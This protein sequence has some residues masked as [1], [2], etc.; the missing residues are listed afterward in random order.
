MRIITKFR[1]RNQHSGTDFKS[2]RQ[3]STFANEFDNRTPRKNTKRRPHFIASSRAVAVLMIVMSHLLLASMPP[4]ACA[5]VPS[6]KYQPLSTLRKKHS[7]I[8]TAIDGTSR[9]TPL[10]RLPTQTPDTTS[11]SSQHDYSQPVTTTSGF[12][13]HHTINSRYTNLKLPPSQ[14]QALFETYHQYKVIRE[15]LLEQ[16]MISQPLSVQASK[17]NISPSILQSI[18]SAG[19]QARQTLLLANVPLVRHTVKKITNAQKLTSSMLSVEDLVQEGT[20]GLT[21]AIDKFDYKL[22]TKFSTYAVYWIRASVIR[23]I[24][25][26]EELIRVP[27]YLEKA[28]RVIDGFMADRRHLEV[29]LLEKGLDDL[30]L[31]HVA[32]VTG[33]S[34]S[35]I[36]EAFRVKQRRRLLYSKKEA[37]RE[38]EDYMLEASSISTLMDSED[39]ET[40][41]DSLEHK[42]HVKDVLGQFLSMKEMEALSWR[43]GLLEEEK[44]HQEQQRQLQ[45]QQDHDLNNTTVNS[46][47]ENDK[48]SVHQVRD[49]QA[50]A[51][52]DL[53]GPDGILRM[54][55]GESV[56]E[57]IQRHD[58][59]KSKGTK[60][61]IYI[62]KGGRWGEAM[63]FQ[64]VGEQMRVS[65][66][67]G[68]RLCSSALK[69]LKAAV[70]EGRLDPAMLF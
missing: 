11:L 21:K 7:W 29:D 4:T 24:Q 55:K 30:D 34:E 27:E 57:K 64:E 23:F 14:I 47:L 20:I 54:S 13:R 70:E 3:W 36:R 43:Y 38:L 31:E 15:F 65:A 10:H 12:S 45:L 62:K 52:M 40:F 67:Y 61:S 50:E 5:F 66:E 28:I 22:G 2:C 18:L 68:R 59:S 56:N 6:L 1:Q 8:Q 37:Y 32:K 35:V 63:S 39:M 60:R 46:R 53:F 25:Q 48:S 51:E 69:K 49:Y 16:N 26:K 42:E 58:D 41:M 44:H 33:F 17:L 9:R 19:Y